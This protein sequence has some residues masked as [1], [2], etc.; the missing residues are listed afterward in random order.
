[1]YRQ[2]EN[3]ISKAS[4]LL[5]ELEASAVAPVVLLLIL[6]ELP[7]LTVLEDYS[8]VQMTDVAQSP[9]LHCSLQAATTVHTLLQLI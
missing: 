5:T 3:F 2:I 4:Y 7:E 9:L 1:L 6:V 8:V